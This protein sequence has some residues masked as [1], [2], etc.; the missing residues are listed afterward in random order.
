MKL[1]GKQ[2]SHQAREVINRAII[3]WLTDATN[4]IAISDVCVI[5]EIFRSKA[6]AVVK[7]RGQLRRH[8]DETLRVLGKAKPSDCSVAC[9]SE[10][11]DG[12]WTDGR[13][14]KLS[15]TMIG[16]AL[17]GMNHSS[18]VKRK[19]KAKQKVVQE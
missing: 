19:D 6:S 5:G 2:L 1:A 9:V 13:W 18:F 4:E 10:M 8:L 7:L 12:R 15:T 14:K 3:E 11:V 16:A 17:G